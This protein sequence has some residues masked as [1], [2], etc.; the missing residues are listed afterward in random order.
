MIII[1]NL[2]D[3]TKK[4]CIFINNYVNLINYISLSLKKIQKEKLIKSQIIGNTILETISNKPIEKSVLIGY[5]KNK[6]ILIN[7][8]ISN[9]RLQIIDI[10]LSETLSKDNYTLNHFQS[11]PTCR[12]LTFKIFSS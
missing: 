9:K 10:K 6:D 12:N 8:L 3:V 11:C 4:D 5:L 1:S 7:N 2:I